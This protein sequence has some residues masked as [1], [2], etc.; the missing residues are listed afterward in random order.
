MPPLQGVWFCLPT[1]KVL[2]VK[3]PMIEFRKRQNHFGGYDSL[4]HFGQ[5][6]AHFFFVGGRRHTTKF[7]CIVASLHLM[8]VKVCI[9]RQQS[10]TPPSFKLGV[11]HLRGHSRTSDPCLHWAVWRCPRGPPSVSACPTR[12]PPPPAPLPRLRACRPGWAHRCP[13]LAGPPPRCGLFLRGPLSRAVCVSPSPLPPLPRF[14]WSPHS[15]PLGRE[16]V[17]M[18][19]Q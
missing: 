6:F 17:G 16:F 5:K 2:N 10:L 15:S 3:P 1:Y 9:G 12:R 8:D 4:A 18:L 13:S 14:P 19:R 7:W 11:L